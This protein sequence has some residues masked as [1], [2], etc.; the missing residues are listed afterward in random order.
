MFMRCVG[1]IFWNVYD[2]CPS[3][4]PLCAGFCLRFAPDFETSWDDWKPDPELNV[5]MNAFC[6]PHG[7]Y[8]VCS[9]TAYKQ[10]GSYSSSN[11]HTSDFGNSTIILDEISVVRIFE[12]EDFTMIR[13]SNRNHNYPE[14]VM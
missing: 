9:R 6:V 3:S 2:M 14:I 10:N 12:A 11:V 5:I 8:E 4:L 7:T 1:R 13:K